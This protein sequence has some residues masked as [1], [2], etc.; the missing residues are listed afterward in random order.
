MNAYYSGL[1]NSSIRVETRVI[2]VLAKAWCI[3]YAVVF[4]A[5]F[6]YDNY[7][8]FSIDL[9]LLASGILYVLCSA[10]S[11]VGG[12]ALSRL[13][14]RVWRLFAVNLFFNLPPMGIFVYLAL[15]T[16]FYPLSLVIFSIFILFASISSPFYGKILNFYFVDKKQYKK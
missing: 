7:H 6:A 2:R 10:I 12:M 9:L 5:V 3:S 4:A 11:F 13:K 8:S 14:Q 15:N 1:K 16:D